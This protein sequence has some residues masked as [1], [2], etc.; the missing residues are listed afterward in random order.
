M[1]SQPPQPPDPN[2]SPTGHVFWLFGLSGAGKSTLA[3]RLSAHLRN[4]SGDGLLLLDGDR[5]R[6]GLSAGLGFS[7]ADRTENLRRAA[8]VARLG[9][10]SGLLVVAAFITPLEEQ[11]RRIRGI[12]GAKA[13]SFV[14]VNAALGTCRD[15]DAKGLYARA[16][17]GITRDVT[18]V[19]AAFENPV[20][21]DLEL[22]T[23]RE[24]V[25]VSAARLTRFADLTL[26]AI[27]R[28]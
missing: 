19:S 11:R 28:V 24:E 27:G 3:G 2:R 7:E 21:P 12:V 20:F 5:I 23:D 18:G 8:E 9:V 10:E 1:S 26:G 6:N 16:A 13:V 22:A 15:R 25:E 4:R 17:A 14:W